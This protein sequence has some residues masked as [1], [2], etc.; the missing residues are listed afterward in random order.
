MTTTQSGS[1]MVA[2]AMTKR[3]P[4]GSGWLF[5][6]KFGAAGN[7]IQRLARFHRPQYFLGAEKPMGHGRHGQN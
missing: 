1:W 6:H 3:A 4:T 5:V 2:G 7:F